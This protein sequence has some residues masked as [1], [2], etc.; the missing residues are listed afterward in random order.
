[1]SPRRSGRARRSFEE[2]TGEV[3]VRITAPSLE[4][5]F[6][7]AGRALAEVMT[8]EEEPG[9]GALASLE[10]VALEASD[11]D[12]LLAEWLNELIHRSETSEAIYADIVVE[13]VSDER[14]RARVRGLREHPLKT[15]VKA[16]TFHGRSIEEVDG[17]YAASVVLDV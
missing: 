7:E 6:A 1:M 15:P 16:V 8:G 17:G 4:E 14:L 9:D 2:H 13:A 11:R 12:A 10:E 3:Q 5:L